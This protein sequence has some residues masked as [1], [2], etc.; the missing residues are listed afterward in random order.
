MAHSGDGAATSGVARGPTRR[1][2]EYSPGIVSATAD[3]VSTEDGA[4]LWHASGGDGPPV[5]L[6]HGGPGLWDNLAS[7][8]DLI[9]D[10]VEVHR[11]DQRGGGRS[12]RIGPYTLARMVADMEAV[13]RHA[14]VERWVAAGH[15]W[16][17]ELALHYTVAHPERTRAL[18]YMLGRGL[19]DSW[20]DAN[21]A[22]CSE[23]EAPR[24][25][26]AQRDR[27]DELS[28]IERRSRD[29]EREFRLLSWFTD[30]SPGFD[31][32][33]VLRDDLDAPYEINYEANKSLGDDNRSAAQELRAALPHVAVPTLLIHGSN[34]PRPADGAQ[35][36][37][38]LMTQATVEV[39]DAG[40]M[41]WLETP[42]TIRRLLREF[43]RSVS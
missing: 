9:E 35:E 8:A 12:S 16:G 32:E 20:R 14:G 21:E 25:T 31:A 23:R 5:I 10:F 28:R 37:G 30:V 11:W 6:C 26:Q 42:D 43:L 22:A 36:I 24:R 29:Q 7:L 39:I 18:V 2:D 40:H 38:R 17:A 4:E 3:I 19:M 13:R 27:F 34:D 15:S 1:F 33:V 41:P